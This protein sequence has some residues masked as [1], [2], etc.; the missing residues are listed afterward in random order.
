MKG[1]FLMIKALLLSIGIVVLFFGANYFNLF[2]FLASRTFFWM[3][4]GLFI[5]MIVVAIFILGIPDSGADKDEG[6]KY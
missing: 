2:G 4:I 3:A 5:I 6:T 1:N